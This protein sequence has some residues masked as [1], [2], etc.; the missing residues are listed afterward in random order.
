M[1]IVLITSLWNLLIY[2]K[3]TEH[4]KFNNMHSFLKLESAI[5]VGDQEDPYTEEPEDWSNKYR[6]TKYEITYQKISIFCWELGIY[7]L[8]TEDKKK[9]PNMDDCKSKWS[10][11]TERINTNWFR[12]D[13]I[14]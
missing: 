5:S 2:Q 9:N 13:V 8:E 1:L 14:S 7:S 6:M 3:K 10:S 11:L 4:K 12:W